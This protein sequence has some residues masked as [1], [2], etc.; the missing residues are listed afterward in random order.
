MPAL[1]TRES[2]REDLQA[3]QNGRWEQSAY[4]LCQRVVRLLTPSPSPPPSAA[5][6]VLP[7]RARPPLFLWRTVPGLV[8]QTG[9]PSFITAHNGSVNLLRNRYI[10]VVS[11][12]GVRVARR[13]SW[14]V[15]D[16]RQTV[17]GRRDFFLTDGWH[18]RAGGVAAF[19][20]RALNVVV[21]SLDGRRHGIISLDQHPH[22]AAAPNASLDL[23]RGHHLYVMGD[24]T[25]RELWGALL[26]PDVPQREIKQRFR[27][28]GRQTEGDWWHY[29]HPKVNWHN[30]RTEF[31]DLGAFRTTFDWKRHSYS[32]HDYWLLFRS[33]WSNASATLS[34]SDATHRP[35]LLVIGPGVHDCMDREDTGLSHCTLLHPYILPAF[36]FLLASATTFFPGPVIFLTPPENSTSSG[37]RV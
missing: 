1:S 32:N 36:R 14:P 2:W 10:R 33:W 18:V 13:L 27:Q 9:V 11:D 34:G 4:D 31:L 22:C 28:S 29:T 23:L 3:F 6:S 37:L 17:S 21:A 5:S 8:E 16:Y 15:L 24:S 25:A 35:S 30:E 26:Q 7:R 19:M 12:A 20:N